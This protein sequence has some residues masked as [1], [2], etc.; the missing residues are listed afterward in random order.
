MTPLVGSWK[1]PGNFAAGALGPGSPEVSAFSTVKFKKDYD[2][3]I[4]RGEVE[5][6]KQKGVATP[7]KDEIVLAWDPAAKQ[8]LI[9]HFNSTCAVIMARG[10]PQGDTLVTLGEIYTMSIKIETRETHVVK[11]EREHY[12]KLEIDMG[13]GWMPVVEGNCTK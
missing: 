13:K 12:H 8:V 2:G 4:Y 11:G 1:C 9:W 10:K 5:T 7:T 6:K 3:F